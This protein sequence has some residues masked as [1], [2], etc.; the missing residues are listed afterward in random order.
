[1]ANVSD[2]GHKIM[3][4]LKELGYRPGDYLAASRLHY[5]FNDAEERS[6]SVAELIALG[7]VEVANNGAIGITPAGERWNDDV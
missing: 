4:K 5:L 2:G 1:M 6:R 3:G 7:L